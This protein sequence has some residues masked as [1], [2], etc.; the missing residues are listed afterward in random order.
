M[1]LSLQTIFK[2]L[3]SIF[4]LSSKSAKM[5]LYLS[6]LFNLSSNY[7]SL[8]SSIY[9]HNERTSHTITMAGRRRVDD[10]PTELRPRYYTNWEKIALTSQWWIFM[11]RVLRRRPTY[12]CYCYTPST[13]SPPSTMMNNASNIIII[14]DNNI[15][16]YSFIIICG[17]GNIPRN[18]FD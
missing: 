14:I 8:A 2:Y 5:S 13:I 3:Q 12:L 9:L 10:L 15:I 16:S 11:P 1:L 17:G 6:G 7:L 4:N 18:P